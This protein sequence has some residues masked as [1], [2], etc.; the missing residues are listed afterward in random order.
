M[1]SKWPVPINHG[2]VRLVIFQLADEPELVA[3]LREA[4]RAIF[5]VIP[6]G[7]FR[8]L[9]PEDPGNCAS[10]KGHTGPA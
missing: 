1:R 4:V 10:Q 3:R 9:S 2:G 6:E 7:V 5:A 8:H